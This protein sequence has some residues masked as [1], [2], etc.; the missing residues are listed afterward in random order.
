MGKKIIIENISSGYLTI[1]VA[2]AFAESGLYDEVILFTGELH[3]RP[4]SPAEGVRVKKTVKY[5]SNTVLQRL[6]TCSLAFV[7]LFFYLLFKSRKYEL[8]MVSTIPFITFMPGLTRRKCSMLIYDVA[9]DSMVASGILKKESWLNRVWEK[10]NRKVYAKCEKVFVISNSM[11]QLVS[12]YVAEEKMEVIYN[13]S[14]NEFLSAVA[15]GKENPFAKE[16]EL[17]GK[18]VVLYSGALGI[19]LMPYFGTL[20]KVAERLKDNSEIT[21]VI[22]GEGQVKQRIEEIVAQ[23]QLQNVKMLPF[24]PFEMLPFSMG[25]ADV[26]FAPIS[27]SMGSISIPSKFNSYLSVGSSVMC[28]TDQAEGRMEVKSLIADNNIGKTFYRGQEQEITDYLLKL[29]AEPELLKEYK[30]NAY[31]LSEEYTPRNAEMFVKALNEDYE[32][33]I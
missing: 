16:H 3:I 1:D 22:I 18:L 31:K 28:I 26:S 23:K 24:Q 21:F 25:T 30:D 17:E 11:K 10:R 15:H 9:P 5:K 12:K 8:L 6:L 20:L 4:T 32:F 13:W 7:H 29:V 19:N 2:N 14:H 33:K 27:P